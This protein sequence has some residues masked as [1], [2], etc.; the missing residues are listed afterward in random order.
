M[1]KMVK[2]YS[3][4]F[5]VTLFSFVYAFLL[6]VFDY[7]GLGSIIDIIIIIFFG[8]I[9]L[10]NKL[11]LSKHFIYLSLPI[12]I[13]FTIIV[14]LNYFDGRQLSSGSGFVG[15]PVITLIFIIML[16]QDKSNNQVVYLSRAIALLYATHVIYILFESL[17]LESLGYQ[18]L[19]TIIIN[20]RPI[21]GANGI[22]VG[23]QV[24]SQMLVLSMFY[25]LPIFRFNMFNS[26]YISSGK[27]FMISLL[28][29]P[30]CMTGTS[31]LMLVTML[32]FII[33]T[34][35]NNISNNKVIRYRL[36]LV[37]LLVISFFTGVLENIVFYRIDTAERLIYYLEQ[38]L[39]PLKVYLSSSIEE[40]II[41]IDPSKREGL[42]RTPWSG[43]FG[44]GAIL[45]VSGAIIFFTSLI[46]YLLI[47][48]RTFFVVFKYRN[49]FS[50]ELIPW[51]TLA[52]SG[53]IGMI[54]W[55]VSLAHYTV[56]TEVGGKQFV[57][58]IIASTVVSL[59]KITS[60]KNRN[61]KANQV[62]MLP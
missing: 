24:A 15:L 62:V 29:W 43:D 26:K 25:F 59:L 38:F 22:M 36:I 52:F 13:I 35:Q 30:F 2:I 45:I 11:Y 20:Y 50:R 21:G 28:L 1:E 6:E 4:P 40:Q 47:I 44:L 5:Y 12:L 34:V 3:I 46:A 18:L 37:V 32:T 54:G 60:I 17:L 58:F 23:P 49:N 33:L 48:A 8:I 41:G 16:Q 53:A 14:I 42:A 51:L 19:K 57:A 27:L 9:F 7:R 10:K 39:S 55:L 56:A 61:R 31:V